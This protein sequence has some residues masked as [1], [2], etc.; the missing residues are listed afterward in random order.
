MLSTEGTIGLDIISKDTI[1]EMIKR[2]NK[3]RKTTFILTTHDL[4]DIENLCE[5]ITIIN[6]GE[7]V[8]D[9]NIKKLRDLYDTQKII[10][11]YSKEKIDIKVMDQYEVVQGEN[12]HMTIRVDSDADIGKLVE[13]LASEIPLK[14]ISI[15]SI[16][17]DEIIK[18]IYL[19]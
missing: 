15:N 12:Q 11:I 6:R 5:N 13:K 14:D 1:L 7:K 17:I 19:D 3:E 9:D 2:I 8:Y 18:K 10:D 16:G 4:A